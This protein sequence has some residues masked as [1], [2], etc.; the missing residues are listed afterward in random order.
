[1]T[2]FCFVPTISFDPVDGFS[3]NL[4]RYINVASLRAYEILVTTT[5][6]SRS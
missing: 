1:M 3:S 6:F 4:H 2:N 5:S